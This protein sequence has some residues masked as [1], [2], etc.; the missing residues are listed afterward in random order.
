MVNVEF[1]DVD[2]KIRKEVILQNINLTFEPGKIYGLLGRNGAGKTTLLSLI[3]TYRKVTGGTLTVAG[4]DP[5]ENEDIMPLVDFL[6]QE[7]YSEES[8]TV[9]DYLQL[10]KRYKPSFDTDYALSLLDEYNIN[11]KKKMM[12]L[13]RGQQAAVDA[14]LGLA[15]MSPVVLFDEVTNGMDAPSREKFYSQVLN[16][17]NRENRIIVLSTHIVSEMDY[18]FDEVI[19]IHHGKVLVDEPVDEFLERGYQVTG[20]AS[21]IDVYSKDKQVVKTRTLGPTK[22]AAILGR[23]SDEDASQMEEMNLTYSVMRMQD[24][25]INMTEDRSGKEHTHEQQ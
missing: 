22:A 11:L 20:N 25:F 4:E 18:L 2:L 17:K 19:I 15:T 5:Y 21:D 3:A 16:A 7:D 23:L 24:L 12:E 14:S 9:E 1:R 13:S 8:T 6:H 10:S